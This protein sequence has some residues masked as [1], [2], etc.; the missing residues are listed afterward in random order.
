M[1]HLRSRLPRSAAPPSSTSCSPRSST[2]RGKRRRM[3]ER[4]NWRNGV[5]FAHDVAASA[6]A[7]VAAF[8]LRF[9]FEVDGPFE[10]SMW[11]NL[12]W[13]VPLQAVFFWRVGMYRGLWRYASLPDL[14]R[15][16]LAVAL[17][18]LSIALVVVLFKVAFI[19]R[20]IV[21]LYPILLGGMM[22][23]S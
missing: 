7:W 8:L 14:Q 17:G 12:A 10:A 20:S 22:G 16:V 5:A 3:R 13:L 1:P 15:I 6:V 4:F 19:P 2:A 21:V 23:G 11:R 9:N 18:A